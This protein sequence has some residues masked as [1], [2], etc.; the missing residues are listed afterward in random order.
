M[1]KK[2]ALRVRVAKGGSCISN[3]MGKIDQKRMVL[4]IQWRDEHKVQV[5]L[6]VIMASWG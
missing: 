3:V 6:K 1:Q 4:Q 5:S 2:V